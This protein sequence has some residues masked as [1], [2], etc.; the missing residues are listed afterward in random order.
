[1]VLNVDCSFPPKAACGDRE[2]NSANST[3]NFCLTTKSKSFLHLN[4]RRPSESIG[5]SASQPRCIKTA[6][7][8][9]PSVVPGMATVHGATF[10]Q[11]LAS[12]DWILLNCWAMMVNRALRHC[13][14]DTVLLI[15]GESGV[16]PKHDRK[17]PAK[18][19]GAGPD[20]GREARSVRTGN[21]NRRQ[22]WG[23]CQLHPNSTA[24]SPVDVSLCPL[25]FHQY[26]Y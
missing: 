14:L 16:A 20:P 21:R 17:L 23:S 4:Q 5:N 1:M 24:C 13:T 25:C 18:T 2:F 22:D 15:P 26:L 19:G 7:V 12:V 6:R 11:R 8:Q 9:L 3:R 10:Q